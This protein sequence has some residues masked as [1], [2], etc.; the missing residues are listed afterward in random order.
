MSTTYDLT[1]TD[2]D[3]R[4]FDGGSARRVETP[5][6]IYLGMV[7]EQPGGWSW[8]P[9]VPIND[10]PE[11]RSTDNEA[12]QDLMAWMVKKGH[13][14]DPGGIVPDQDASYKS[15]LRQEIE[16]AR[17]LQ[18]SGEMLSGWTWFEW[19]LQRALA[20]AEGREEYGIAEMSLKANTHLDC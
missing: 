9:K 16:Q 7:I 1:I 5:A 17:K 8:S 19:G 11:L 4:T 6:G 12:A 15:K 2:L 18:P 10:M 20:L 3:E 14:A 13:V